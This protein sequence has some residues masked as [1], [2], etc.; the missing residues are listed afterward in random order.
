MNLQTNGKNKTS[1]VWLLFLCLVLALSVGAQ[2]RKVSIDL[3]GVYDAKVSVTPFFGTHLADPVIKDVQLVNKGRLEVQIPVALLP[4]EFLFRFDYRAKASDQPYPAELSL[5]VNRD[6]ITVK[7]NPLYTRGDSLILGNDHENKAYNDFTSKNQEW[8]QQLGLLQQLLGGY[9][10]RGSV[11]VKQACT[12]YESLR[13]E[14]NEWINSQIL[15]YPNLFVPHL[16]VFQYLQPTQWDLQPE[17]QL[18]D[19]AKRYFDAISLNDTLV[20]RS[21]Q[22][23]EFMGAYVGLFGARATTEALR[24]SLFTQAGRIACHKASVGNP[25]VYGWMVDYF[26]TG[27]ESNAIDAGLKML[28]QHLN[29]PNCLTSKKMAIQKRLEGMKTIKIGASAPAFEAQM[30]DS[31]PF[32]FDGVQAGKTYSLLIFYDSTCGHCTQTIDQLKQWYA[33]KEN[34]VWLNVVTVALNDERKVWK[35]WHDRQ[36]LAWNDMWAPGG[37]NS[38]AAASYF[39]LSTPMMYVVDRNLKIVAMPTDV[40]GLDRFLNGDKK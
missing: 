30:A 15:A 37:I 23:N 20:L 31:I 7:I 5:F 4:G 18:T 27:Y 16:F 6:D 19:M 24:D 33:V 38:P 35:E 10:R 22:L 28:A 14:Y 32:R 17:A 34:A 39:I 29:N 9:T 40:A 1:G 25:K 13:K 8:R 36:H 26:Y 2:T 11:L 12:E 21:R 3:R